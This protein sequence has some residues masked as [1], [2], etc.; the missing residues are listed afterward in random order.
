ML[1]S[2]LGVP[3]FGDEDPPVPEVEGGHLSQEGPMSRF[4]APTLPQ[5]PSPCNS[6]PGDRV[7]GRHVLNP[8]DIK[9]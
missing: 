5:I 8:I 1:G 3:V 4:S 2:P 7:L 9:S 6:L